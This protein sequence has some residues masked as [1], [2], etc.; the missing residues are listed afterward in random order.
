PAQSW[1]RACP[2]HNMPEVL[3]SEVARRA[4]DPQG[5]PAAQ[6]SRVIE[7]TASW[8]LGLSMIVF[9]D[10]PAP[11]TAAEGK[12]HVYSP[13]VYGCLDRFDRHRIRPARIAVGSHGP[14]RECDCDNP[15]HQAV[16]GNALEGYRT[17]SR[18]SCPSVVWSS[19]PAKRVL[20]RLRQWWRLAFDRLRRQ[21]GATVR[22]SANRLDRGHR[23]GTFRC[24]Q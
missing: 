8:P 7:K 15:V 5:E 13:L 1:C 19:Q 24:Q 20:C 11:P 3:Q 4:D 22:R 17:D 23:G 6:L 12:T 21:L 14:T 10:K 16:R 9:R 2:S 18:R